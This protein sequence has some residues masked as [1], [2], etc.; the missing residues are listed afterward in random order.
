M[1]EGNDFNPEEWA[2]KF[3]LARNTTRAL[4]R[5]EL[6]DLE[7][8]RS[9]TRQ[10]INRLELSVGQSRALMCA[11]VSL[12]NTMKITDAEERATN[13]EEPEGR[14]G[15]G[16]RQQELE[17]AEANLDQWLAKEGEGQGATGGE[18]AAQ[19]LLLYDPRMNL[20]VKAVKKKALQVIA[21]LPETVR[22]RVNRRKKDRLVLSDSP[23]GTVSLKTQE[24]G[25]VYISIDEWG[26]ANNRI[27]AH[28]L[29]EGDLGRGEV[30]YYLSYLTYVYELA[31][32][33]EWMSI[34]EYDTRYREIQAQHGFTWGTMAPHLDTVLV[35][36]QQGG[37]QKGKTTG[38]LQKGDRGRQRQEKKSVVCRIFA[39]KG[40]CPFGSDCIYRHDKAGTHPEKKE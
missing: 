32:L 13:G 31:P 18:P 7:I 27:L 14:E 23:G 5:E 26:A 40:T 3:H 25:Q 22:A 4:R 16:E 12:G 2:S 33:Y 6:M 9:M 24:V 19:P 17:A 11:V 8:L 37:N 1:A 20:T 35:A 38:T 34:L 29:R 30:E 36:R 21:F 28:M 39:T 10:D 15:A